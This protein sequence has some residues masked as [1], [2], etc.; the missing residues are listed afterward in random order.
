M[1][2]ISLFFFSFITLNLGLAEST[3]L[4]SL[5]DNNIV[6]SKIDLGKTRIF[7]NDGWKVL[8][9]SGKSSSADE[10]TLTYITVFNKNGKPSSDGKLSRSWNI[11]QSNGDVKIETLN[12]SKNDLIGDVDAELKI[13]F[14][15]S[16]VNFAAG[17]GD[18]KYHKRRLVLVA[19]SKGG[20]LTVNGSLYVVDE[21]VN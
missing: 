5:Y 1:K 21:N 8:V 17:Q 3:N 6:V 15:R 2:K 14:V 10:S 7:E 9:F 11:G 19:P 4:E 18:A 12:V 13:T 20:D 16:E